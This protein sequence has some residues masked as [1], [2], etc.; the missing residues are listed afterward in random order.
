MLATGMRR[1]ARAVLVLFSGLTGAALLLLVV[2]IR[3]GGIGWTADS[4]GSW[5]HELTTSSW[6]QL[7]PCRGPGAMSPLDLQ[8]RARLEANLGFENPGGF[9]RGNQELAARIVVLPSSRRESAVSV[10]IGAEEEAHIVAVRPT[11]SV[12]AAHLRQHMELPGERRPFDEWNSWLEPGVEVE[13]LERTVPLDHDVAVRIRDR[14][15]ESILAAR[16]PEIDER[17][18]ILD[19]VG[20]EFSIWVRGLGLICA[21]AHSPDEGTPAELLVELGKALDELAFSDETE[22]PG[23]LERLDA[24]SSRR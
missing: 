4:L 9:R 21:S 3:G 5:A 10:L 22:R 12:Q 11:E 13:V 24:L 1:I 16:Y 20:Y 2:S 17:R 14:F 6:S 8:L 7:E 18:Y 23:G 19:G 15:E